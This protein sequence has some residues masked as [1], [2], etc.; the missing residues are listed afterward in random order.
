MPPARKQDAAPDAAQASNGEMA[1]IVDALHRMHQLLGVIT[2]LDAL[3]ER[4]V[5]EGRLVASAEASSILLYEPA[6]GDLYFYMA[7]GER[8]D[9]ESLKR[10][11]RL[12]M[13]Q[14]IAG[15]AAL[16]REVIVSNDAQADPRFFAE[17]DAASHIVTRSL[18]A[19][20][21][22][23]RDALIGVLEVVNK[24]GDGAFTPLDVQVVE[25][26]SSLAAAAI[27]NAR[28]I[29]EHVRNERLAA[30]GL[31]VT[32]LSHYTKN[33]VTSLS[34]SADLIDMGLE[35]GNMPVLQRAWPIFKRA[36]KRI[37]DFVQ[38]MLSFS[39]PR[40]PI[41]ERCDIRSIMQEACSAFA[42]LFE[43]KQAAF[44]ID[45][46]PAMPSVWVDQQG[47]YRCVLNLL[48]NAADAVPETGGEVRI[49]AR[50]EGDALEIIVEDNGGGVPEGIRDAIFDP[51]FSTK[52]S[53]GT[54]LGLAVTRKIVQEHGGVIGVEASALGGALFRITIPAA[55]PLK[56]EGLAGI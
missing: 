19:A 6:D 2:D 24:T 43:Q 29:E 47:I 27:V 52:G 53:Q 23:D 26:F 5:D 37:A 1:R 49:A 22:I 39:K 45:T 50:A 28:L 51:F 48:V 33:I 18:I 31:A 40:E 36:T 30:I 38:D 35:A 4:L 8:G 42:E 34:A 13:G 14:G 44:R 15:T 41:R 16:R 56:Q 10:R 46:A 11:V 3:L 9:Q 17:A 25:M 55:A 12:R 7:L 21:M 54:G 20:P 32:S